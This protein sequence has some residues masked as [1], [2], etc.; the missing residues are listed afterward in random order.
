M[1]G[2]RAHAHEEKRSPRA[3]YARARGPR[4][5]PL[6]HHI[7]TNP[8]APFGRSGFLP[9]TRRGN[10]CTP[11]SGQGTRLRNRI[12]TS[13]GPSFPPLP[14]LLAR[15]ARSLP[16]LAANPLTFRGVRWDKPSTIPS[17]PATLPQSALIG[18]RPLLH[19]GRLQPP[20]F[21]SRLH[22]A[23]LLPPCATLQES[24]YGL[25]CARVSRGL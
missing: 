11:S 4:F 2:T 18:C 24:A 19:Y 3:R 8:L 23:Y 5:P 9:P 7:R 12:S 21:R 15:F 14:L 6:P 16:L 1:R 17:T 10:P 13:P 20:P 25:Q 22:I